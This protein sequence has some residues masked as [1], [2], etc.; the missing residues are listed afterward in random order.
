L[1]LACPQL[2]EVAE[3]LTPLPIPAEPG[4]R[5]YSVH[6]RWTMLLAWVFAVFPLTCTH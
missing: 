1:W 2:V 5:P 3:S 4:K 6:H